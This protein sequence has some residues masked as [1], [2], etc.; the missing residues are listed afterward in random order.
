MPVGS[1][2]QRAAVL[3]RG[4]AGMGKTSLV[5][6]ACEATLRT[7]GGLNPVLLGWGT[8]V[9]HGGAPA[10]WPWMQALNDVVSSIGIDQ[11]VAAAGVDAR[12]LARIIPSLDTSS[13]RRIEGSAD[14]TDLD[15]LVLFDATDRWLTSLAADRPLVLVFDDLQWADES[16]VSL[17]EFV[18]RSQR[19]ASFVVLGIYRPDELTRNAAAILG[20][21]ATSV[22]HFDVAGLAVD[23][24]GELVQAVVGE[25]PT[26]HEV[27]KIVDRTG[28]NPFF[29][30]EL[31]LA[32]ASRRD[33]HSDAVPVAVREVLTH[34]IRR[35]P[36]STIGVLNVA[37]VCA[38]RIVPD[39]IGF[40]LGQTSM[41][42]VATL[43][44][45]IRAGLVS[46]SDGETS[47]AHDL[48]RETLLDDMEATELTAMHARV[49]VALVDR[50]DRLGDVTTAEVAGHFLHGIPVSDPDT[51]VEWSLA[52]AHDDARRLAF[53]DAFARLRSLRKGLTDARQQIPSSRYVEILIVEADLMARAGET[54][55]AHGLLRYAHE[56]AGRS[57]DSEAIADVAMALAA[58]GARFA[59][60][61]D[62]VVA[63]LDAA[64]AL[65]GLDP[66]R[67][68]KVTATLARQLQHSVAS[69]RRRAMALSDDALSLCRSL[70]DDDTLA[71]VLLARHD[72]CWI[73][74]RATE[75]EP[76]ARELV[77]TCHRLGDH[78]R[79]AQGLLLL[80]NALLE[81]GSVEF[82]TV[83]E[84]CLELYATLGQPRHRYTIATRRAC[85]ALIDGD[86]EFAANA[87]DEA[88]K[89]GE[90][91]REPDASNVAM[92]Q[93]VELI[94]ALG[95]P[96]AMLAFAQQ[97]VAHWTGAPVHAHA[98]A[99][100]FCA[101]AGDLARAQHHMVAVSNLGTWRAD[102]SYLRSVFLRELSIAATLTGDVALINELFGEF[103]SLVGECGVN[104][105][106]IAFA[107]AH[108][109]TAALLAHALGD[110]VRAQQWLSMA[111]ATYQRLGA[112]SWD[113]ALRDEFRIHQRRTLA[114]DATMTFQSDTVQIR[115]RET[116]VTFANL[117]G[118][119]DLA[120]LIEHSA[121]DVH[122]L[123]LAGTEPIREL[124][125]PMV[126]RQSL[127]AY[128]RRILE[129]DDATTGAERACDVV[130]LEALRSEREALRSEL[131]SVQRIG[132]SPRSYSNSATERAR[133]AV[134]ARIRDAIQRIGRAHPDLADHLN[135][136][137]TTGTYC[138]YR[139]TDITWF[140]DRTHSTP[141]T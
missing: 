20:R 104:G 111:A 78:E 129:L 49:A 118:L 96:E 53:N 33:G 14:E 39:V 77:Q 30:R 42:V 80:A 8:G 81:Q 100:G 24:V 57:E 17:F 70:N 61:R 102:Q 84:E 134:T 109:H 125:E 59:M 97:A 127:D 18:A 119:T 76:I 52:A 138:R 141:A 110:D 58:L 4:Q 60:R 32:L 21:L 131:R 36:E 11:F 74:G 133:K 47:F 35:L 113:V 91:I 107:G 26:A 103:H 34:R 37:A 93:R 25:A 123:S 67:R 55:D 73:P 3:V 122:V 1:S 62:A 6:G 5:R 65:E 124:S 94:R 117:K 137:I 135:S 46:R 22:E 28:G 15:R 13:D 106:V 41:Q 48:V 71:T 121:C 89:L 128:R 66:R 27:A 130:A 69:D 2:V 29:V 44:P 82:R 16:T 10:Y 136:T 132:G 19:P 45:A 87:I 64:L 86:S 38:M 43:E 83:L 68:A 101:R 9:E 98:I 95:Q 108:S 12:C 23:A 72:V 88:S 105:A 116:T 56:I 54:I 51:V 140:I 112:H 40:I 90:Q 92:S 120:T 126:D 7:V 79:R 75:R 139:P 115:Y 50:R 63:D 85:L 31:A 99:A 114:P